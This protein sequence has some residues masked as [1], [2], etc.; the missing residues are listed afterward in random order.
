MSTIA[1]LVLGVALLAV[2]VGLGIGAKFLIERFLPV[3]G[4]GPT[5]VNAGTGLGG[6][7]PTTNSVA[8]TNPFGNVNANAPANTNVNKNTSTGNA[9]QNSKTGSAGRTGRVSS[10]K[11]TV[12]DAPSIRGAA[13]GLLDA[14]ERVEILEER[15]NTSANEGVLAREAP[16]NGETA[17]SPSTLPSGRGVIV[18]RDAGESYYVETTDKGRTIRGYVLKRDVTSGTKV[19]FRVRSASGKS[20]WVNSQ[21]VAVDRQP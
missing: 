3:Q 4:S 17:G 11:V 15:E 14:N 20:G 12:R 19:W 13:I 18:L 21:F 2:G 10:S 9:N 16:F 5:N 8:N 7:I 6:G 1:K